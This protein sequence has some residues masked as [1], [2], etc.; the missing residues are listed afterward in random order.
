MS[1][2]EELTSA[3]VLAE[4]ARR[5]GPSISL[6]CPL[7]KHEKCG[8]QGYSPSCV[9]CL[10][11]LEFFRSYPFHG[12][13]A[14]LEIR[15]EIRETIK[16]GVNSTFDQ[17]FF[18]EALEDFLRDAEKEIRTAD[19][20]PLALDA[21]STDDLLLL[22]AFARI[23]ES[24]DSDRRFQGPLAKFAQYLRAEICGAVTDKP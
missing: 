12:S 20:K 5:C 17:D 13:K 24:L 14:D 22:S 19:D 10:S 21:L 16:N 9:N 6:A 18:S 3:G 8:R 1:E 15:Q 4:L 23:R 7:A 2:I 11:A